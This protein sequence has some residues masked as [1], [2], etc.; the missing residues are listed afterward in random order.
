MIFEA[1]RECLFLP[2]R[3]SANPP[4]VLSSSRTRSSAGVHRVHS[5]RLS[6]AD[7][8]ALLQANHRGTAELYVEFP[9]HHQVRQESG[10]AERVAD[11]RHGRK[12]RRHAG[13]ARA[14][15]ERRRN[16]ELSGPRRRNT[17]FPGRA[18]LMVSTS[19]RTTGWFTSIPRP[20]ICWIHAAGDD[21]SPSPYAFVHEQDRPL[22]MDQLARLDPVSAPS[23]HLPFAASARTA[24]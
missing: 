3:E 14:I 23:V 12:A 2:L 5:R 15:T 6:S 18:I 22:V 20:R 8:A 10:S 19:C 11:D 16:E 24:K 13:G 1:E 7:P 9:A 17:P 4:V 21:D